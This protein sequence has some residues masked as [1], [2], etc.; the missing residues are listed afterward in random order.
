MGG[1]AESRVDALAQ[2]VK[3]VLESAD[4]SGFAD[5]LDPNVQWGAPD[6]PVPSCQNRDQVLRWYERGRAEG[7]R[8][9]VVSVEAHGDK[10]LVQLRVCNLS[11]PTTEHE[12]WQ[13][14]R[15]KADRIVDMRGFESRD[16][17]LA[18]VVG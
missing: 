8:A 13:V 17:A 18:N 3:A 14:M 11:D 15:C 2:R 1:E 10:I 7:T 16:E 12:R 5:F 6:D 4:L 9:D